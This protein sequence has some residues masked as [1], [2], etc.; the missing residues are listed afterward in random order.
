MSHQRRRSVSLSRFDPSTHGKS[1]AAYRPSRIS[2]LANNDLFSEIFCPRIVMSR[3]T[4]VSFTDE[5]FCVRL[6]ADEIDGGLVMAGALQPFS[7]LESKYL[8]FPMTLSLKI[9]KTPRLEADELP[10]NHV[11][12]VLLTRSSVTERRVKGWI[13]DANDSDLLWIIDL[14]KLLRKRLGRSEINLELESLALCDLLPFQCRIGKILKQR[15]AAFARVGRGTGICYLYPCAV[16]LVVLRQLRTVFVSSPATNAATDGTAFVSALFRQRDVDGLDVPVHHVVA[17]GCAATDAD[18]ETVARWL[19]GEGSGGES[20]SE[21]RSEVVRAIRE[22]EVQDDT[23]LRG[24]TSD[25][26]DVGDRK[27]VIRALLRNAER[28]FLEFPQWKSDRSMAR[29]AMIL[30]P[31]NLR[32]VSQD[33]RSDRS[34]MEEMV[35]SNGFAIEFAP[36]TFKNDRTLVSFALRRSGGEAFWFA[37]AELRNDR[38]IVIEAVRASRGNIYKRLDAEWKKDKTVTMEAV[39]LDGMMLQFADESLRRDEQVTDAAMDQNFDSFKFV[40]VD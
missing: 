21:A 19:L 23:R 2:L 3:P 20:V 29:L 32:F 31:R 8:I 22:N 18:T 11:I 40:L 36:D 24:P 28:A 34:F 25:E 38:D 33:I 16:F 13:L 15:N 4:G 14:L 27:H 12:S 35:R 10:A 30:D 9:P 1:I 5:I 37:S 7:M 6:N 39:K 17:K 26:E